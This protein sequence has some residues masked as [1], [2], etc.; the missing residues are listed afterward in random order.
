MLC[1]ILNNKIDL[2]KLIINY[3]NRHNIILDVNVKYVF[4]YYPVLRSVINLNYEMTK[5]IMNYSDE[6]IF[7]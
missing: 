4:G 5:L 3:A 2:V 7:F 6:K 1:A